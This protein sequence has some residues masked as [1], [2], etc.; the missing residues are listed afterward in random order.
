MSCE[1]QTVLWLHI[2]CS[3][4]NGCYSGTNLN[5][6]L[7]LTVS[8]FLTVEVWMCTFNHRLELHSHCSLIGLAQLAVT[9]CPLPLNTE[10]RG[11]VCLKSERAET[12]LSPDATPTLV[13]LRGGRNMRKVHALLKTHASKSLSGSNLLVPLWSRPGFVSCIKLE[14]IIWTLVTWIPV[15]CATC[16]SFFRLVSESS[17]DALL[18]RNTL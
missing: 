7:L 6:F 16:T 11:Q 13:S 3:C 17:Y 8:I 2:W 10:G 5:T 4:V 12:D 18:P 14:K 15:K 9:V 1:L